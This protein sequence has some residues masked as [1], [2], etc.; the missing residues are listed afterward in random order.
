MR[1]CARTTA[2]TSE[3]HLRVADAPCI[4]ALGE[5]YQV[6]VE[7]DQVGFLA[8]LD[9]TRQR[10]LPEGAGAVDGVGRDRLID[11][12]ALGRIEHHFGCA[13][14]IGA[15]NRLLEIHERPWITLIDR[16]IAAGGDRAAVGDDA[17]PSSC[18]I[19]G[20]TDMS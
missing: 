13:L 16:G 1:C 3:Q 9:G 6:L 5:L 2:S 12:Q 11:A 10:F 15:R 14:R 18:S 7:H 19:N 8:G 4:A 20:I 17:P